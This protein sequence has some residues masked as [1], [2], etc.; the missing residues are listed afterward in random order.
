[1]KT[2]LILFFTLIIT[3]TQAQTK[4]TVFDIEMAYHGLEIFNP[5]TI[6]SEG[7]YNN[8]PYFISDHEI[9]LSAERKGQTDILL[10]NLQTKIRTW[11]SD[12]PGSE[13]SPKQINKDGKVLAVR[14]EKNGKQR[15]YA[16]DKTGKSE[17]I[18]KDIPVA[19]Y[20]FRNS[21]S[22][23]ATVLSGDVM[24]LVQID[25]ENKRLVKLFDD[26]GRGIERLPKGNS[27]SYLLRNDADNWD[28]Y[29]LDQGSEDAYFVTEL[30]GRIQDYVWLTDTQILIGMG[31]K[32]YLYDTFGESEWVHIGSLGNFGIKDISRL[33]VSPNGKKLAVVSQ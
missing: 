30:P 9:L 1:M 18:I 25:I 29:V 7:D 31:N 11:L 16:Y 24:D 14:L 28:L 3:A 17:E 6:P 10:Y 13:Y 8:Q 15:L 33:A 19:Y 23:L 21:K 12:T 26:A 20:G 32:L 4:V 2:L 22:I 5:H 27:M